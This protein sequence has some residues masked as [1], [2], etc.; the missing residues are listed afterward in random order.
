VE[1]P[2][3]IPNLYVGINNTDRTLTALGFTFAKIAAHFELDGVLAAGL[4]RRG[5][6]PVFGGVGDI[7]SEALPW[8]NCIAAYPPCQPWSIR[9]D[10][11][12]VHDLRAATLPRLH[13]ALL[14]FRM[15][16]MFL[17]QVPGFKSWVSRGLHS[18]IASG[19]AYE[20]FASG[21]VAAGYG[22]TAVA[23]TAAQCNSMQSR[24][25][26]FLFAE[27]ALGPFVLP[28]PPRR[29]HKPISCL[30]QASALFFVRVA[31]V[32][33]LKPPRYEPEFL[34]HKPHLVGYYDRVQVWAPCRHYIADRRPCCRSIRR[35]LRKVDALQLT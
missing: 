31:P 28:V 2:I 11:R 32:S 15:R 18:E 4:R 24:E 30:L 5:T 34:Q 29:K 35:Q 16:G 12:G 10:A 21:V 25:R 17:E 8:F 22:L 23:L 33:E 13:Q 27:S 14:H 3:H 9:G 19:P 6:C 20:E 7:F 26:L 1:C